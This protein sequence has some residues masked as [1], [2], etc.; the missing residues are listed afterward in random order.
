MHESE[1]QIEFS[2]VI[3]CLN[4]AKTLAVCIR[5]AKDFLESQGIDGEVIV[6]DNGS[7]DGSQEIANAEQARLVNVYEPGYGSALQGGIAAARGQFIIMGDAD[8]SYDFSKIGPFVEKLR[9]GYDLVMGNR[10]QGG[11]DKGAMPFL[12][13]YLGNPVLSALGRLFFGSGIRDFHCGLRGFKKDSIKKLSLQTRGMEFA[14]EMVVKATLNQL[15]ITEVP[16]ALHKDGRERAPHLNTWS[17]GWR[18]LRFLLLYSPRWLFLYPGL[19]MALAGII[20]LL[21]LSTGPRTLFGVTFDIHT[22]IYASALTVLGIQA[23]MFAL[24]TKVFATTN[25]LLPYDDH[26]VSIMSRFTLEKGLMLG[27][28]LFLVG[29]V[30]SAYAVL[31][32]SK[33]SFGGLVPASMM[34]VVIPSSMAMI[35]GVQVMLAG[36]FISVLGLIKK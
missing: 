36:F 33:F 28:F 24:F 32:W 9:N 27:S 13:R 35:T 12:H 30:G 14:S 8:D 25:K 4:E 1:Q 34:R 17:D 31:S 6:A 16:T 29:L 15:K 5:K 20:C 23:I 11:I 19:A 10:F 7:T 26:M 2:V 18:H 3:P 21:M 22:M